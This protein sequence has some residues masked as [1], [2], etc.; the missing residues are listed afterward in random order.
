MEQY[1]TIR[2]RVEVCNSIDRLDNNK[3]YISSNL[4]LL[5][6]VSIL[7]R[8]P[9]E[10]ILVERKGQT[11]YFMSCSEA[12]RFY[13]IRL[14]AIGEVLRGKRYAIKGYAVKLITKEEVLKNKPANT[15][16]EYYERYIA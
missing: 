1:K 4:H 12:S 5:P 16:V 3:G 10:P 2:Q 15:L 6:T 11:D 14:Q 8:I 7:G 13:G 9:L